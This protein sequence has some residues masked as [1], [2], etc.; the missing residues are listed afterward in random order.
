MAKG[1]FT[2]LRKTRIMISFHLQSIFAACH[3]LRGGRQI[4]HFIPVMNYLL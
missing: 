3:L 1:D 2:T 4:K